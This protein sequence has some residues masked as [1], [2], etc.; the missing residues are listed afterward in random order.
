MKIRK[1]MREMGRVSQDGIAGS[2]GDK[3]FNKAKEKKPS[4]EARIDA[5][6]VVLEYLLKNNYQSSLET[7]KK[8]LTSRTDEN[9]YKQT[10]KALLHAFD[11]GNNKEFFFNWEKALSEGEVDETLK[12]DLGKLEFY[13]QIYFCIF[14]IHP[15]GKN[16]EVSFN[17]LSSIYQLKKLRNS[18]L[19]LTIKEQTYP[20]Q[21]NF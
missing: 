20:K 19:F 16:L 8:E 9:S 3:E 10:I 5:N 12:D 14:W 17:L 4:K 7:F 18:K 1:D 21:T 2:M 13:F 6:K 15:K 11:T